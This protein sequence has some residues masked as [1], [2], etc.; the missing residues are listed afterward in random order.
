MRALPTLAAGVVGVL[1]GFGAAAAIG[2]A[3]A[4]LAHHAD[5]ALA[6]TIDPPTFDPEVMAAF[7]AKVDEAREQADPHAVRSDDELVDRIAAELRDRLTAHDREVRA[8]RAELRESDEEIHNLH[9]H[10]SRQRN[11]IVT[12]TARLRDERAA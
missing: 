11:E 2:M 3:A 8:L 1:T 7:R 12:L 5:E 10:L 9:G 4:R 6:L